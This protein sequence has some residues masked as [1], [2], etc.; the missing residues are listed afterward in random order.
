METKKTHYSTASWIMAAAF[1]GMLVFPIQAT[2][3]ADDLD[4]LE[5][6]YDENAA[7]I[8]AYNK[9]IDLKQRQGITLSSQIATLQAQTDK[10][11]KEISENKQKLEELEGNIT[12]LSARITEKESVINQQRRMLSELMRSSYDDAL[13]GAVVPVVFSPAEALGYF[14]REDASAA[15]SDKL[16][17]MLDSMKT[18]RESLVTEKSDLDQKK[19]EASDIHTQLLE[20]NSYLESAESSKRSL[21]AKTAAEQQKYATLV[22]SLEEEQQEIEDEINGLQAGEIGSLSDA[23]MPKAQKGL[24][25]WPVKKVLISQSYGMTSYAKKGAY[26]GGPHNGIDFGIPTGT[27][28]Y[29]PLGGKVVAIGSMYKNSRWYGYGRWIAIDHGNGMVTL[30]GHLSSQSVK[31]GATVKAGDKIGSSGN[32]GY[33]TG[34]HLHFSVFSAKSFKVVPSSKV[35]GVYLPYGAHVN[36]TKYL[37]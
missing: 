26:G 3:A 32:T 1:C 20:Q 11:E 33:S 14:R 29:A 19:K 2:L 13:V 17:D 9:I 8:K 21:L 4:D 36:P 12:A 35:K 15:A 18:L 25:D 37:P 6:Q 7:K 23:D 16:R 22:K 10:L 24:L 31:K 34:P 27:P 5:D 28:I 30:Y